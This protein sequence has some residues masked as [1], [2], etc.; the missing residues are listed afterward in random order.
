MFLKSLLRLHSYRKFDYQPRYYNEQKEQREQRLQEKRLIRDTEKRI[1]FRTGW[2]AESKMHS[3]SSSSFR[4]AIIAGVL[5]LISFF[6]LRSLKIDL[7]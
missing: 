3:S 5:I 7:Y 6:I 1:S 2:H 4:I